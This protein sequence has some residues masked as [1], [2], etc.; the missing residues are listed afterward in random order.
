MTKIVTYRPV[1][2]PIV[3]DTP[4]ARRARAKTAELR[5]RGICASCHKRKTGGKA[6]C[7][8]CQ[9]KSSESQ[10]RL[11]HER[12]ANGDCQECGRPADF[13]ARCPKCVR[14]RNRRRSRQ[15]GWRAS[16]IAERKRVRRAQRKRWRKAGLC[17]ECGADRG[18][19]PT[20]RCERHRNAAAEN[21]RAQVVAAR[22]ARLARQALLDAKYGDLTL[23]QAAKIVGVAPGSLAA[24]CD[25]GRLPCSTVRGG[26]RF[27]RADVMAFKAERDAHPE[28]QRQAGQLRYQELRKARR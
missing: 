15:P 13:K 2:H 11:R 7:K 23:T 19:S 12:R 8:I 9:R 18:G 25:R 24:F 10:R 6:L 21:G 17:V 27:R 14:R 16:E 3:S 1:G 20:T 28:R 5:S 4:K 26:R 22:A